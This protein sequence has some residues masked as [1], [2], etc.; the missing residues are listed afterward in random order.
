MV[1]VVLGDGVRVALGVRVAGVSTLPGDT[2]REVSIS[3]VSSHRSLISPVVMAVVPISLA[4][5]KGRSFPWS[6]SDRNSLLGRREA[7]D[8]GSSK[9]RKDA[10][11]FFTALFGVFVQ[12]LCNKWK[13]TILTCWNLLT[14]SVGS[15]CTT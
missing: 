5:S 12:G 14:V 9:F 3:A 6:C 8:L 1:I 2:I 11:L 10:L 15:N 4:S 13:F 7:T